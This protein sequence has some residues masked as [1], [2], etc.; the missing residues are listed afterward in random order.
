MSGVLSAA[1]ERGLKGL[2]LDGR[3][4][5]A[6]FDLPASVIW[7]L[8]ATL[9]EHARRG[10]LTYW[11]DGQEEV[12]NI[13]LRPT[14]ILAEQMN[15]FHTVSLTLL[16]ALKRVPDMYLDNPAVQEIVPLEPEEEAWLRELWT[17]AHR[18]GHCVYG[19]L[20]AM[21]DFTSPTW[22]DTLAFVEPNLVGVGGIVLVPGVEQVMFDVIVPALRRVA[23]DLHLEGTE[24]SRESFLRELLDHLELIGRPGGAIAL[25]DYK[26]S[27]DG[28]AEFAALAQ[29]YTQRG[30]PVFYAD[31]TELTLRDHQGEPE[32]FYEGHRI[33]LV[34]RDY[35]LRDFIHIAEEGGD[36]EVAKLL[37]RRNQM[38]SSMAGDFDHKSTF[39]LLTDSRFSNFFTPGE[40]QLLRRHVLW[41]R[42]LTPRRTTDPTGEEIDLPEFTRLNRDQ[43]VIK[44]NRSYGGDRVMIGPSV[45]EAEWLDAIDHALSEPGEWVVQRMARMTAYEF[46][47]A[48]PDRS[49]SVQP[50]YM[51]VGFAPTKYGTSI[52]GRASQKQVVNV[53]QRGGMCAVLVG[54]HTE[55]LRG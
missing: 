42:V 33:D 4:R 27:G 8:A 53:A 37:F 7:E 21:V 11:R 36:P 26:Y 20:D 35:E 9:P 38:V 47:V 22:K 29:Y 40:R 54:R 50:F 3:L 16:E 10:G 43:L 5:R 28:P 52:L 1:D 13:L 46:P 34:Y 15:Y 24:D 32:V 14:G 18:N 25:C 2:S 6:F 31:P 39:E 45:S 48:Q 55:R 44:P 17:P 19:R 12:I 41:T 30:L 49:I 51:V 23:P